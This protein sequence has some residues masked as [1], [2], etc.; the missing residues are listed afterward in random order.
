MSPAEWR[1][2]EKQYGGDVFIENETV[3][4]LS[5]GFSSIN[6]EQLLNLDGLSDVLTFDVANSRVTDVGLACLA[7]MPRLET[8]R[9][10]K[11]SIDGSALEHLR[12]FATLSK[13]TLRSCP[14]LVSENLKYLSR[15][16]KLE[17]LALDDSPVDDAALLFVS[18]I[19]SLKHL[20]LVSTNITNEGMQRLHGMPN[21]RTVLVG[22]QISDEAC[23]AL[24]MANPNVSFPSLML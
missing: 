1:D 13:L 14:N 2:H 5:L 20:G 15:F 19:R 9:A 12:C 7:H 16:T 24:R 3:T 18:N 8:F 21:L 10:D 6:D 4:G 17:L 22:P 23:E 11:S